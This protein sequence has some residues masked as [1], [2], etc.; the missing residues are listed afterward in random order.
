MS[1]ALRPFFSFIF[2][3]SLARA[4]PGPWPLSKN[5]CQ[6]TQSTGSVLFLTKVPGGRVEHVG[7]K[8]E[9]YSESSS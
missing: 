2:Q 8:L 1:F 3:S 4:A 7:K 9:C 6:S 5:H